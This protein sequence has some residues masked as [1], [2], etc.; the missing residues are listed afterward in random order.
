[1]Y[2]EIYA[3]IT[4]ILR[5]Y[6][7]I[8]IKKGLKHSNPGTSSFVYLVVNTAILWTITLLFY[9]WDQ[10]F[11]SGFEF[12]VLAGILAPGIGSNLKDMGISRLGVSISTPI[13]SSNTLFSMLIAVMFLGEKV[14][15]PILVGAVLIFMGVNLLT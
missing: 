4:A 14:T 12:F 7:A 8:P 10:I 13:V 11:S 15:I 1:V 2:G 3:L 6:S 9:P 5:G